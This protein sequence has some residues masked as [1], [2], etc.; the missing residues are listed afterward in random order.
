MRVSNCQSLKNLFTA[1]IARNLRQLKDLHV[2]DCSIEEIVAKEEGAEGTFVFPQLTSLGLQQLPMLKK[3]NV[4]GCD[5]INPF[6]ASESFNLQENISESQP[7]ILRQETSESFTFQ[8]NISE[9]QLDI[10]QQEKVFP[11]LEELRLDGTQPCKR[12]MKK[13]LEMRMKILKEF[14]E[15]EEVVCMLVA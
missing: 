13:R 8:E 5:K 3:L 14:T 15:K 2:D 6:F 4:V 9:T 11:N 1:S 12:Y 7:D 10:L